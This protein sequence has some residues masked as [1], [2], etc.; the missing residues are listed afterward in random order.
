MPIGWFVDLEKT[1]H[2]WVQGH[3]SLPEISLYHEARWQVFKVSPA[4]P[5]HPQESGFSPPATH[6]A[7]PIGHTCYPDPGSQPHSTSRL[8]SCQP[9]QPLGSIGFR[10][11]TCLWIKLKPKNWWEAQSEPSNRTSSRM[12]VFW[13]QPWAHTRI[14]VLS[15][16]VTFL[17]VTWMVCWVLSEINNNNYSYSSQIITTSFYLGVKRAIDAPARKENV[18]PWFVYLG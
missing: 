2:S 14:I 8:E 3:P 5:P 15:L 13:Y 18:R 12:Q 16:T 6:C 9:T 11:P 4:L 10:G 1:K 17:L 7:L